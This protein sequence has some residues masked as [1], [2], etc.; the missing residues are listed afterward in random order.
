MSTRRTVHFLVIVT[1]LAAVWG[2]L[3]H[4]QSGL[5]VV[6]EN[7]VV[8][9]RFL[10]Q[11]ARSG[12]RETLARLA[13]RYCPP[14]GDA[15][16]HKAQFERLWVILR[17]CEPRTASY[18]PRDSADSDPSHPNRQVLVQV[19]GKPGRPATLRLEWLRVDGTWYLQGYKLT[20]PA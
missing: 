12:D 15:V 5:S 3:N 19:K 20:R 11:Q 18:A 1:F 6:Q 17:D 13:G 7:L 14:G 10:V 8:R 4:M 16:R 2:F 9:T